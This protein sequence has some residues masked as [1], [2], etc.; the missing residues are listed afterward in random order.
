MQVAAITGDVIDMSLLQ[1]QLREFD[2]LKQQF[3]GQV[4]TFSN[5][6]VFFSPL[7]RFN[8]AAEKGTYHGPAGESVVSH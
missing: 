6:L 7:L 2:V 3:T 8:S 4:A 5:S 1:F